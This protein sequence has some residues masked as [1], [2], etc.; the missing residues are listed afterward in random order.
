M[1]ALKNEKGEGWRTEVAGER[2]TS[3]TREHERSLSTEKV[4]SAAGSRPSSNA[5]ME[6]GDEAAAL[7]TYNQ[8]SSPYDQLG[9]LSPRGP[10]L[11]SEVFALGCS[12]AF[13]WAAVRPPGSHPWFEY[14]ILSL[15]HNIAKVLDYPS[16]KQE[17]EMRE[18]V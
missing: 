11:F 4:S 17:I 15:V 12:I 2:A 18:V 13:R 7:S 8:R 14:H 6:G 3:L 9:S 10:R 16:V 1:F 5:S